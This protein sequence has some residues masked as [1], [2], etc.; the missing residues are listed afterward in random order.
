MS[1]FKVKD[2]LDT[3]IYRVFNVLSDVYYC[4]NPGVRVVVQRNRAYKN[5][6]LGERCFILGTG[7]SINSITLA[8]IDKLRSEFVFGVNSLYKSEHLRTVMPRY[9]CLLDNVY[10]FQYANEFQNV[11]NAYEER[12]PTLIAN[13]SAKTAIDKI[14][15]KSRVIYLY[16]K[17][18]PATKTSSRI[19]R[20]MFISMNV[21]GSAILS[22]IYMGF[23]QVYLLGC[24]YNLFCKRASNHCYDDSQ[25]KFYSEN[26]AFYLKFYGLT[27]EFHY[28]TAQHAKEEGAEIVNLTQD[29][30]LDAYPRARIGSIFST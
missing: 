23:K 17:K 15:I 21:V 29:S 6:H 19:D 12:P 22:A 14:G 8:Q 7:P 10:S 3:Q 2:K 11:L 25:E 18:F 9:Y 30:L 1:L 28:L 27:T 26:L 16:G 5:I 24:D 13:Y 4:I 20:N